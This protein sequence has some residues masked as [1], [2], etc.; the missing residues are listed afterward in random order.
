MSLLD[1]LSL[2]IVGCG[3]FIGSAAAQWD[4][5]VGLLWVNQDNYCIITH[6]IF[7]FS[8]WL[9]GASAFAL[10]FGI[11][12]AG[13]ERIWGSR[14]ILELGLF[15]Y[16]AI[17]LTLLYALTL[18]GVP[19]AGSLLY[20]FLVYYLMASFAVLPVLFLRIWAPIKPTQPNE[21]LQ[22]LPQMSPNQTNDPNF[23]HLAKLEGL[24]VMVTILEDG[25]PNPP[26]LPPGT[27]IR[28]IAGPQEI[29]Y[30]LVHLDRPVVCIRAG[31]KSPWTLADLL[32]APSFQG[33]NMTRLTSIRAKIP[34]TIVNLL[35][36][37]RSDEPAVDEKKGVYFARGIAKR[38]IWHED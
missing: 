23:S 4:C 21:G 6:R 30:Q 26:K 22:P 25:S 29:L 2:V 37:L 17:P 20:I 7:L 18:V 12:Y 13:K 27:I 33:E 38:A 32:I 31:T 10:A 36:P 5:Y 8:Y 14:R 11:M 34:I 24:R 3:M 28:T 1:G 16:L 9:L 35:S 19:G 15:A